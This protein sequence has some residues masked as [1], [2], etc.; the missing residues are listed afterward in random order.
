MGSAAMEF[1]MGFEYPKPKVI[2]EIGCNHMGNFDTAI[3]LLTLA[4]NAGATVGK[5]QKRNPKELLTKEQYDAPHPNPDQSYGSTYGAHR[6]F[7]ELSVEQHAKLHQHCKDIGLEYSSSV[8][9]TTSAKEIISFNPCLI[10]VGSPSN[11]HFEMQ[12]VLRDE[13]SGEVHISTGMT[14][15]AEIESIVQFW[16]QGGGDAK[17]R[18]VLYTCTS[19]YPVS[20]KDVCMLELMWMKQQFAGRVKSFGFSG[21]HLGIAFD[22]AAYTL[23]VEWIE[24]HFTKDRTWKGTD[25]AASL[26][27][28]VFAKLIRDLEATHEALRWRPS[29]ILDIELPQRNKLKWGQY[30]KDGPSKKSDDE[31]KAS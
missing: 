30:N 23:G 3:E 28:G 18:V 13:W 17:N 2:A 14:T 9:D 11:L 15:R 7:L 22:L 27:P 26:E 1:P 4:K 31:E 24:R 25:H 10:K 6:E 29:E 20:F 16:E 5:F 19:G 12:Q 21:H 8:W